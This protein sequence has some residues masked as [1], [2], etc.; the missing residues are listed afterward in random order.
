MAHDTHIKENLINFILSEVRPKPLIVATVP[1]KVF[2]ASDGVG[3]A[4]NLIVSEK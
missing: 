2:L 4:I 1:T 3:S